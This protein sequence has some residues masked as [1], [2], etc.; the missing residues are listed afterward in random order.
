MLCK[1]GSL[2]NL[3]M[4]SEGSADN[5][6]VARLS[7]SFFKWILVRSGLSSNNCFS[8]C[9]TRTYCI[10]IQIKQR[11]AKSRCVGCDEVSET[12]VLRFAVN[13]GGPR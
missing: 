5:G 9:T 7:S 6:V 4:S 3:R 1:I 8:D 13:P 12:Q 2:R 10:F 11:C